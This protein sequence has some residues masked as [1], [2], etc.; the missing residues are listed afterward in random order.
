LWGVLAL[1]S[2][3]LEN[4]RL[5][6]NYGEFDGVH[7]VIPR[8]D[9]DGSLSRKDSPQDWI[10]TFI[11]Y[12]FPSSGLVGLSVSTRPS[13]FTYKMDIAT[14]GRVMQVIATVDRNNKQLFAGAIFAALNPNRFQEPYNKGTRNITDENKKLAFR[15]SLWN[16]LGQPVLKANQTAKQ[17]RNKRNAEKSI[18]IAHLITEALLESDKPD[19][20]Y[21]L[22]I[23]EGAL[24]AWVWQKASSKAELLPYYQAMPELLSS[25]VKLD[26]NGKVQFHDN[27][28]VDAYTKED[29]LL[30]T[31]CLGESDVIDKL[32]KRL[33]SDPEFAAYIGLGYFL[34]DIE[35]PPKRN[36]G[37]AKHPSLVGQ[38]P[39]TFPDCGA[40]SLRSFFEMILFNSK[41]SKFDTTKLT[42]IADK[43]RIEVGIT[44]IEHSLPELSNSWP[45]LKRLIWFFHKYPK[46]VNSQDSTN[47]W[48]LITSNLEGVE[49]NTGTAGQTPVCE[50]NP[51][52]ANMLKAVAKLVPD[53]KLNSNNPD[54]NKANA[55]TLTNL[56]KLFSTNTRKIEWQF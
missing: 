18:T 25:N 13:D 31:E 39:D 11:Q 10:T 44:N 22:H 4:I 32:I 14:V 54:L 8:P 2:N 12:L 55:I 51:G 30:F 29:Y 42:N 17:L 50:I 49:Y 33:E 24:S 9:P 37:E 40:S 16:K 21:P 41:S 26:N 47:D 46:P 45:T 52:I 34:F 5:R 38:N 7:P 23:V 35:L 43:L 3:I 28:L 6:G 36:Y 19:N 15:N 27:F 20:I 53:P 56:C 1:E 48:A